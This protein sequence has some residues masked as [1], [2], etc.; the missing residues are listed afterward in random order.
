MI[1]EMKLDFLPNLLI[2]DKRESLKN[3]DL[4]FEPIIKDGRTAAELHWLFKNDEKNGASAAIIK[5]HPGGNQPAHIHN[6]HELIYILEGEMITSTGVVKK[7]DLV[8]LNPGSSHSS[9]CEKGC[10][11]L[12]VWL[13]PVSP[14]GEEV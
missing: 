14:I 4:N 1:A 6:G 2:G 11:A 12:I 3:G 8:V 10:L 7:N 9:S 5:Y 13:K